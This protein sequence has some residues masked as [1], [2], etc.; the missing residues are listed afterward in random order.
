MPEGEK[1][2]RRVDA[3]MIV[4]GVDPGSRVTGYGVV[5]TD[6][7][8]DLALVECGVIRTSVDEPIAERLLEI[9]EG[10]GVV[11]ERTRP[12]VLC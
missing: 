2:L 7:N 8:G 3:Y 12:D 4:L 11:I 5:A 1:D 10:V 9:L 6:N